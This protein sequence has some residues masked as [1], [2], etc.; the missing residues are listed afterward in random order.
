MFRCSILQVFFQAVFSC[1]HVPPPGGRRVV[2]G[3][4]GPGVAQ[5]LTQHVEPA[6]LPMVNVDAQDGND[7][8]DQ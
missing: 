8:I 6:T 1:S 3:P 2:G 4:N 5:R 7:E